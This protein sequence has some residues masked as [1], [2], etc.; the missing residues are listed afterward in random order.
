MAVKTLVVYFCFSFGKS[1]YGNKASH[2][3]AISY[4]VGLCHKLWNDAY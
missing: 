1:Q 3:Y 2:G 4:K